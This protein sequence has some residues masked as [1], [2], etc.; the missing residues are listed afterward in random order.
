MTRRSHS[1]SVRKRSMSAMS[2]SAWA[3]LLVSVL[4][5]TPSSRETQRCSNT[6]SMA[7]MP[8]S[9]LDIAARSVSDMTPAVRAAS[10]ML[11]EMGSQPPKTMSSSPARGTKSRISGLRSSSRLPKRMRA[12]WVTEPIGATPSL[13]ACMTPAMRV[14][15]TAPMPGM[16]RP[17]RPEATG[18][19]RGE[20]MTQTISDSYLSSSMIKYHFI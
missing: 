1:F 11:G 9:S 18:M 12:I 7:T 6:A 8:S 17:S 5:R 13:R 10:Y 4:T 2:A 16:S 19:F 15:A 3:N 14:E 20:V